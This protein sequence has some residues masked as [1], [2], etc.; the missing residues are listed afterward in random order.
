MASKQ[1]QATASVL[2]EA[3]RARLEA[4]IG[5]P[6]DSFSEAIEQWELEREALADFNDENQALRILAKNLLSVIKSSAVMVEAISNDGIL[7][8][9]QKT[10]DK[11]ESSRKELQEAEGTIQQL[12]TLVQSHNK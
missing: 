12:K 8:L 2:S 7:F 11:I 9:S 6:F 1:K 5:V 3:D 4:F 10:K